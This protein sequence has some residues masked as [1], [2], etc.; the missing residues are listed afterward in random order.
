VW[1]FGQA[2]LQG[3]LVYHTTDWAVDVGH[4]SHR[5]AKAGVSPEAQYGSSSNAS[6]LDLPRANE[7]TCYRLDGSLDVLVVAPVMTDLSA[8]GGGDSYSKL[9]KGNLDVSGE[10]FIWTSNMAGNR[11]DAFVVRFPAH[12]LTSISQTDITPPMVSLTAPTAGTTVAETI[13]V[14]ASASDDTGSRR[15]CSRWTA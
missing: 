7:I 13:T 2:P 1:K 3:S 8:T 15:S 12:L 10:Y 6:Q 11:L 14:T 9:P 4:F 5:N